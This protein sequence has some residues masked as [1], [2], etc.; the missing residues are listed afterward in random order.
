MIEQ[1]LKT[2]EIRSCDRLLR[3]LI[4]G[5]A[6]LLIAGSLISLN[7]E[8]R[9]L[10]VRDA[11]VAK[12]GFVSRE[13]THFVLDGKPLFIAGVN[14]HYLTFGSS[15]EVVRVLDDAAAM[16]ANVVRTFIQPVIGS[17][18]GGAPRTIWDWRKRANSSDLG[19]HGTYLIYWDASRNAMA[20]H[21]GPNG[22]QKLDFLVNEA[23]KRNLRLIVAFL[24]FWDYTGGAQQMRAWYGSEDKN[25]F[26]FRDERTKRD[27]KDL[28][29]S[30]LLRVNTLSGLTYKDDPTIFAWELMNEAEIK[31]ETLLYGWIAEMSA[32][33]KSIDE[34][35]MVTSGQ[36]NVDNHLS[37]IKI[38]TID[39]ATWHGY[40]VYYNQTVNDLD[41]LIREYC[42]IAAKAQKPVLLEEF[43]YARSNPDQVSAYQQ[44]LDTIYHNPDCAGWAVWRLV[45]RQDDSRYPRDDHDQF[46]VHNDGGALWS[47]LRDAAHRLLRK[48]KTLTVK[49][50]VPN[51]T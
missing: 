8:K 51:G 41:K 21:E 20:L 39:F 10:V 9:I 47:V 48:N 38:R 32:Y 50:K 24:D 34:N 2:G 29:R 43:G 45:S 14:N 49:G 17:P 25:S 31:P 12:P 13:G 11:P 15:S 5:F 23:Q 40:P 28:L 18:D 22:M 37:D 42:K 35:H 6:A 44:W 19:V 46:D 26:F 1:T 4:C 16:G 36:A 30:V 7:R 27:Y 3:L 33:V